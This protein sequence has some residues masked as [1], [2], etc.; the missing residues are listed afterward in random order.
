[1]E[2][3]KLLFRHMLLHYFD[4]KKTGAAAYK[5][6]VETYGNCVPSERTC[7]KWFQRFKSDD[8]DVSDKQRSSQ[9]TEKV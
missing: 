3:N 7:Q 1:M 6:L 2:C 8:Y 5:L 9:V 4:L